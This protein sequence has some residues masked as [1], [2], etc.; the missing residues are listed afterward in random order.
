MPASK[1][2]SRGYVEQ[3]ASGSWRAVIYAGIDPITGKER[4]LRESATT[5]KLAQAALA[6]L[7]SQV[8]EKRHPRTGTT[9]GELLDQWMEVSTHEES[10]RERYADLIRLYLRPAFGA[11]P[12]GKLDAE[13]LELLYARLRRC[14]DLCTGRPKAG[15]TCRPLAANS[16]RK[17]HFIARAALD[18]GV[19]WRHLGVNE[20]EVARPPAF[21]RHDPDPPSPEEAAALLID[22]ADDPEWCLFL[23]LTMVTG[24]RRGEMCA[25]RWT[26]LDLAR[27][28]VSISRAISGMNEKSTKTHQGR[29]LALDDEAVTM[30]RA[31]LERRQ[32]INEALG[33]EFPSD[34]FVFSSTPDGSK[35]LRPQTATQRFRRLAERLK[36][37]STRLHSLRHYSATEL[38]AAGVDIRTVA[39]RLGH[40]DG[41][42][43]TLKVYAAW[44]A[45]ADRRA[46]ATMSTIV[47]QPRAAERQPRGPYEV[48]AN[49]IR[50]RIHCGELASGAEL[51]TIADLAVSHSVSVGTAQRAV[52]LLKTEGLVRTASGR[53][54]TVR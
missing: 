34:G 8:D 21:E 24:S 14:R 22:A 38:L 44:V 30:L 13:L 23:W 6:R 49:S 53:R 42:A 40:G 33:V 43:T 31:H 19:R 1:R 5:R 39:G 32:R 2:R 52:A 9:F 12:A 37:R 54:T 46:A 25:I 50:S 27:K 48:L 36:L 3:R 11:V 41:G 35:P 28:V 26:D 7:Q 51:P 20:A 4:Y 16:I 29:R 47:P 15:H 45:E 10:T 17:V 18:L